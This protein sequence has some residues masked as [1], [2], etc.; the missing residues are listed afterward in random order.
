MKT[1][2]FQFSPPC[3]PEEFCQYLEQ[4]VQEENEAA[5]KAL[6]IK[7]KWR[8]DGQFD[9]QANAYSKTD[10]T[11][12]RKGMFS[13]AVQFRIIFEVSCSEIFRGMIE[14]VEG[15]GCV[16]RGRF[17]HN[18]WP[19]IGLF[20]LFTG[21]P[22]LGLLQGEKL[23]SQNMLFGFLICGAAGLYPFFGFYRECDNWP[24]SQWIVGFL[25]DCALKWREFFCIRQ[26]EIED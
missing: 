19:Y 3:S 1:Y 10:E 24:S 4:R 17:H 7:L 23:F 22:L 6:K 15:G 14:P 12:V 11:G 26:N 8:K 25:E 16:I 21:C 9:L 13:I 5:G 2:T 18:I 20:L